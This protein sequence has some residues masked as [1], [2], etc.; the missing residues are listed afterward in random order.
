MLLVEI[1]KNILKQSRIFLVLLIILLSTAACSLDKGQE[2]HNSLVE[3]ENVERVEDDLVIEQN[4]KIIYLAGGCFWGL[5]GY[6][7]KIPGILETEVG[8]ANGKTDKTDYTQVAVTDHAETVKITYDIS[9]I[10]LAEILLRYFKVIDPTSINRQGNDVGRQY[11][12]GIYYTDDKD[13]QIIHKVI[14]YE[15]EIYGQVAVEVD[16][17]QNFIRAEDYHQD[18]LKKNPGGYCHINLAKAQEPL[19]SEKYAVP[20]EEEIK[21]IL[22]SEAYKVMRQAGTE[23]PGSSP[24]NDEN[25]KGIYVDKITGEPLFSSRDKFNSGCGWPSFTKPITTEKLKE[26]EDD[27]FG[28]VR[29]EVKTNKSDSHLGHV[30]TDGPRDK[31]GLRYCINGAALRFIPYEEMDSQGYAEYK[32]FCE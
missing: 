27:S 31:G 6:F 18:Y 1:C 12:T 5:E 10:S 19:F 2:T 11:R 21:E 15:E 20:G 25:R 3:T 26:L 9:R 22:D 24:L 29:T 30:F 32:L 23:R 17:L 4:K 8:Y 13:S 14:A 28:M 16:K 7:Q